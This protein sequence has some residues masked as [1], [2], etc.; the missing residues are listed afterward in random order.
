MKITATDPQANNIEA[1]YLD[2]KRLA[3]CIEA[4]EEEGWV[5]VIL[6]PEDPAAKDPNFNK[7]NLIISQGDPTDPSDWPRK[8]LF[9]DVEIVWRSREGIDDE[10]L[11]K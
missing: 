11:S 6:P 3:M 10:G 8:Q 2:G 9:G 7:T 4:N 1:V 5:T